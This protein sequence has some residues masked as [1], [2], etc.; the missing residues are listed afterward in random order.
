MSARAIASQ[1]QKRAGGVGEVNRN[2]I[3]SISQP[4]QTRITIPQAL[5]LLEKKIIE[6]EKLVVNQN[7]IPNQ[8]ELLA[9]FAKHMNDLE[10]YKNESQKKINNLE[11]SIKSLLNQNNQL[12]SELKKRDDLINN[13][14]KSINDIQTIV[15]KL[16][17]K[18][19]NE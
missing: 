6:I 17:L 11:E 18:M 5:K 14:T 1:K 13:H 16:S 4:I 9:Q 12:E 10:G 19:L 15:N 8:A 3:S 7:N 2:S